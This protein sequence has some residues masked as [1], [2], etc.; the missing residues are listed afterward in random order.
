MKTY[1]KLTLI[2]ASLGLAILVP[3][4]VLYAY[5]NSIIGFP[6][7]GFFLGSLIIYVFLL[8]VVNIGSL[9]AAF[10]INN[11]KI[12]GILLITCGGVVLASVRILGIPGF[13]LFVTAGIL[14]LRE[15]F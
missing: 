4:I 8:V 1:Q 10:Q 9:Y 3:V 12:A 2:T 5:I 6:I 15:K 13:V 7:L 11:T 14:A